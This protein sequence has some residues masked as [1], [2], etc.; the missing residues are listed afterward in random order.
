M[1][2]MQSH[3]A[4]R[5]L[6]AAA[7]LLIPTLLLAA[8]KPQAAIEKIRERCRAVLEQALQNENAFVRGAAARAAGESGDAS[9]IPLLKKATQ[10]VYHTTRLFAL[11]GLKNVSE[12]EAQALAEKMAKDSNVWVQGAALELLGERKTPEARELILP[13]L[14]SPDRPVRLAAAAALVTAGENQYLPRVLKVASDPNALE[15]YQAIGY[16]GKMPPKKSL[17][18]LMA[19]LVDEEDE[20]VYYSL[21]AMGKRVP[22]EMAS[23]LNRL[24]RSDNPS[25]RTQA[26][27]LMGHLPPAVARKRVQAL[28]DDADALV[29]VSAAVAM[30]R[31]GFSD[32]K[33]VFAKALQHPDYGVRSTTARILGELPLEG[34]AELLAG[35]LTD[36]N[37]RVR[38]S[39]VRA[40]GMMGGAAAF[41]LL[42]RMLDDPQEAVRAYAAGGLMKLTR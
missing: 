30:T 34:K 17:P 18:A 42:A 39:A 28:C 41:P 12:E 13:H 9:L 5:W 27:L 14:E 22:R 26:V 10:D 25:V 11:K 3:N 40:I 16:L 21:Q 15:R 36:A 33:A 6:K 2:A 7:L 4:R 24:S 31:M 29:R 8:D 23:R 38:T 35:V 1:K 19:L 37:T 20:T 32:C